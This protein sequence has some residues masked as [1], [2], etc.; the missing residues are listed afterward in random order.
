MGGGARGAVAPP[1]S[2]CQ[3]FAK[4]PFFASNF[5]ISMPTA[6]SRSS[7]P[8]HFQIHSAVSDLDMLKLQTNER[9]DVYIFSRVVTYESLLASLQS[10][11]RKL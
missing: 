2:F 4:S 10:F 3:I 7:Q 6:P 1:P 9:N 11:K 5:S 8:P